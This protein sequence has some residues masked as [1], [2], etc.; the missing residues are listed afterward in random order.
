MGLFTRTTASTDG[1]AITKGA[2]KRLD[3]AA[4]KAAKHG[5]P[6]EGALAVD[7]DYDDGHDVFLAVFPDRVERY[8]LGMMT[9]MQ[10]EVESIPLSKVTGVGYRQKGVFGYVTVAASNAE[11]EWRTDVVTGPALRGRIQSLT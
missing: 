6:V 3:K 10:R 1:R 11:I 5:L 7:H 4:R 9:K 2:H 8:A